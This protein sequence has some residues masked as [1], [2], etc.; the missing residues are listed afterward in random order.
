MLQVRE[1]TGRRH[2]LAVLEAKAERMPGAARAII[3]HQISAL[4]REIAR[5]ETDLAGTEPPQAQV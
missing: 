2:F 5:L 4:R 3:Q 1:P